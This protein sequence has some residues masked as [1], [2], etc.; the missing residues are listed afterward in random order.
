MSGPL[1]LLELE[2]GD[3]RWP[4]NDGSPFLFCA[5]PAATGGPYCACH[6]AMSIGRGTQ[7][8]REAVRF[9]RNQVRRETFSTSAVE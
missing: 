4:V 9:A 2:P 8:E 3:C 5:A 7:S 6:A 1:T